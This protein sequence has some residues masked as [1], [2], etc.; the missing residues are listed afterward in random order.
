SGG[1]GVDRGRCFLL[2]RSHDPP[3][4]L[5]LALARRQ[6]NDNPV[7]YVQYAHARIASILR[8]AGE[9]AVRRAETT[10][11]AA[12]G[13]AVSCRGQTTTDRTAA[14]AGVEPA[15]RTLLKRLLELPAEVRESA[16]R[17]APHR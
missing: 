15:E 2:W 8:K 11:H 12:V 9:D 10:D 7:Y 17:R 3:V 4:D 6:S 1:T 13:G 5:D 14:G 16:E